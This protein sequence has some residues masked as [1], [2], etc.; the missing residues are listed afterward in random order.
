MSL[1]ED[2]LEMKNEV[3]NVKEQSLA[4]ELYQDS[5][6]TNKRMCYA[7]TIVL[8]AMIISY[9][10]TVVVFLHNYS[11]TTCE[12]T[13]TNTRTQEIDGVDSIQN[14][15]IINGDNYGENKAN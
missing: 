4:M 15:S 3:N 10:V 6:K 2:I 1:R 12:E 7:F 11:D 13:V 5:K 9:F 8:T 14:S